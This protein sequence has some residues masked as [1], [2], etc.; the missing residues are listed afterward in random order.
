MANHLDL[1]E[2]EQLD[3]LKH[4]WKQYGNPITWALIVV[5]AAFASW[6]FYHYWQRTQAMQS[7][8]M[9]DEVERVIG[10]ADLSKIDRSFSDMKE[11][12]PST[13][14]AQQAG[15]L[16]AKQY[17]ALGKVDAAKA[18]LTWVADKASD[19]GY[20]AIA[21]LRLAAILV[22]AKAF[23]EAMALLVTPFP[24]EFKALVADRKGD[25]LSIQGKRAEAANEYKKAYSELNER[26][27]YKRL[28]EFKLN[29][30]G[31]DPT[32]SAETEA[33]KK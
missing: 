30:F 24:S 13:I 31:I 22:E 25:I 27:E 14:Y 12:F 23:D 17:F 9:F 15:L 5:L 16:V 29:A 4:F 3:Q 11:R 19:Q 10:S 20:Q 6:N 32:A 26:S 2:Q 28:V 7:A 21:K 18:T 1:E 8:A 33:G